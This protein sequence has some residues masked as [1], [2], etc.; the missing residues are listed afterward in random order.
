MTER[1]AW[2]V[3]AVYVSPPDP[4]WGRQGVALASR[5]Q[6]LLAPWLLEP[7]EHVGSTAVP[8]LPA[9][10]V[11]DLQAV[12]AD[13]RVTEQA[14]EALAGDGWAYVP[15]ELDGRDLRRFFVRVVDG[16]R[17]A[18][19]HL[20]TPAEPDRLRQRAF[21]DALRADASLREAYGRLKLRLAAEH[22]DDREAYTDG[23]SD[24]VLSAL[25]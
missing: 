11:L 15:P 22:R 8:G 13:L 2:A 7:V 6:D 17:A 4:D 18:H 16:H 23:K 9:K 1:P 24:F 19:L 5:V 25:R 3:E 21:R 12:V 14:A 20:M 10:P